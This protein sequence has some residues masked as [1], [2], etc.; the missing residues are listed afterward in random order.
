VLKVDARLSLLTG[1]PGYHP[2][3]PDSPAVHAGHP[4]GCVDPFGNPLATD[5][6]GFPRF[7]R[8]DIGAYELQPIGFATKTVPGAVTMVSHPLTYTI[9]LTNGGDADITNVWLVDR[10]PLSLVYSTDSLTATSGRYGYSSGVIT[11]TGSVDAGMAVTLTFETAISRTVPHNAVITNSAVIS[12]AGEVIT[13]TAT[14]IAKRWLIHL[15]TLL[16][17]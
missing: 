8:C 9:V 13:R 4:A 14:T 11:W 1:S 7:G 3:L 5:Q 17:N 2:L 15:P 12:G 10:F 16:N 6:R